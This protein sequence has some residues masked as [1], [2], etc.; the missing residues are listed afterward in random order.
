MP[1]ASFP[2]YPLVG[3]NLPEMRAFFGCFVAAAVP[4]IITGKG[5]TVSRAGTA[6]WDIFLNRRIGSLVSVQLT[7]EVQGGVNENIVPKM[8]LNANDPRQIRVLTYTDAVATD[9]AASTRI[10]FAVFFMAYRMPKV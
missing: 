6:A 3:V 10:H 5:F 9:P 8:Q 7:T 1:T 4:T 2:S